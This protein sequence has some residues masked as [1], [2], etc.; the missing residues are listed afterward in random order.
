LG[1]G[2]D[3]TSQKGIRKQ[4]H[5]HTNEEKQEENEKRYGTQSGMTDI[6]LKTKMIQLAKRITTTHLH[7]RFKQPIF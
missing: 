1:I 2:R 4:K 5:T 3:T 7:L 6:T